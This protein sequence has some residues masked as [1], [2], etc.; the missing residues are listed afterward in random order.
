MTKYKSES[1]CNKMDKFFSNILKETKGKDY[2]NCIPLE[3]F[4][5]IEE[6]TLFVEMAKKEKC[7][8]VLHYETSNFHQGVIIE[9]FDKETCEVKDYLFE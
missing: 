2:M 6:L 5:N 3:K 8:A 9:L 4:S 7:G 1:E